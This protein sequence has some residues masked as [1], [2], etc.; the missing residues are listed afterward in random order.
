MALLAFPPPKPPARLD[1]FVFLSTGLELGNERP[2]GEE[3]I[4][5]RHSSITTRS[6]GKFAGA[7]NMDDT[8]DD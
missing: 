4:A 2:A 8:F 6:G 1:W 3:N 7:H 5:G